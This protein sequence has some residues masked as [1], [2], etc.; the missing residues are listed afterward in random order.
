MQ[1]CKDRQY[2]NLC[3]KLQEG[4]SYWDREHELKGVGHKADG[5]ADARP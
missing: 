5:R 2:H 3:R 1:I 4:P